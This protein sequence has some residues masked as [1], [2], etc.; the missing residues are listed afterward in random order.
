MLKD[1]RK[2]DIQGRSVATGLISTTKK[3]AEATGLVNEVVKQEIVNGR[4]KTT[5]VK[6]YSKVPVAELIFQLSQWVEQ[7]REKELAKKMPSDNRIITLQ[8]RFDCIVAF[9]EGKQW[10]R[11][12]IAKIDEVFTDNKHSP[13]I[14]FSS[15]HKAKGLE[16]KRIFLLEPEG[17]T[18]PHPMA[19]A[20][21]QKEQEWNLRYVAITRAIEELVY[22]S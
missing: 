3:C 12:V 19:K 5:K 7:E 21:W 9:T 15:I 8:D 14:K 17:A 10:V 16:A 22:V 13:G 11:E 2:A 1:G 4:S 18:V 6:D 20:A